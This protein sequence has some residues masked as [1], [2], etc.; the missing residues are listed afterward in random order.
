MASNVHI[1]AFPHAAPNSVEAL[2]INT[3]K[4]MSF[5]FFQILLSTIIYNVSL[6]GPGPRG[7][8]NALAWLPTPTLVQPLGVPSLSSFLPPLDGTIFVIKREAAPQS[9][10]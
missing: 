3:H 5:F 1:A 9:Q 8:Y 4:A 2:P 7:G 10:S 6:T